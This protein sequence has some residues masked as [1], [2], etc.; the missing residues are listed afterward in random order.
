M[1]EAEQ[2]VVVGVF[3]DR[4]AVIQA[5]DAL[6]KAGFKEDQLGF[7]ART[8]E[9]HVDQAKHHVQHGH[10]PKAI[11]RGIIGGILGA[12]DILLVPFIGPADATNVLA[13]ALPVTEEAIDKLPYPG[14]KN[15]K[16]AVERPDDVFRTD[17]PVSESQSDVVAPA[18][19][20]A[21]VEEQEREQEHEQAEQRKSIVAGGVV[22]GAL[23][24]AA[25]A[26]FLPGIGP[27]VAGGIVAAAL[28]GG[29]IGS[30]AGSFLGTLTDM[31]IPQEHARQYAQDVKEGRTILT[32]KDGARA[33]EASEILRQQGAQNIQIH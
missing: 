20:E 4:K 27:I 28:G 13:T 12:A 8:S 6:I 23:G 11:A 29:A 10:G 14:S 21:T 25:A 17:T 24:A 33:G 31:G 22:G 7:V 32:M 19:Q 15:D 30:V 18:Q 16:V 3:E 26:L 1:A 5:M 9:E 2:T